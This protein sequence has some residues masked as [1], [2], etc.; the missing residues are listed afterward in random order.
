MSR[1]NIKSFFGHFTKFNVRKTDSSQNSALEKWTLR[2][3]IY[4]HESF[5]HKFLK[6][7]KIMRVRGCNTE[8]FYT[9]Y[10]LISYCG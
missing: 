9:V 1:E 5:Q 7:H 8:K 10:E 3:S 4:M 2:N 6:N